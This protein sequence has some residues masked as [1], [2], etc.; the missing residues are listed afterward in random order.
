MTDSFDKQLDKI[1]LARERTDW[2]R[3]R[4][5]L[6]NERTFSA[7]LRTGLAA[8]AAGLGI[9]KLLGSMGWPGMTRAIGA[10]LVVASA[11]I[12]I[13]GFWRYYNVNVQLVERKLR[14]TSLWL[15]TVLTLGLL[16]SDVLAFILLF[17]E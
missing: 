15:L 13:L 2:A 10:I 14:V 6:A 4:N 3:Q 7:W 16:L 17:D 8:L 11:L 12:Y 5:L 9:A 1:E